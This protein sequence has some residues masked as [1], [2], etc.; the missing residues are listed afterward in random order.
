MKMIKRIVAL[1]TALVILPNTSILAHDING[2]Q[3]PPEINPNNIGWVFMTNQYTNRLHAQGK[4]YTYQY[5]NESIKKK[6]S[7]D[8]EAGIKLWGSLIKMKEK[9]KSDNIIEEGETRN[10][11]A[12]AEISIPVF[13]FAKDHQHIRKWKITINTEPSEGTP[14]SRM[15]AE[16]KSVVM[17]HEIG[18]A[19][20]LGDLRQFKNRGNLM[21]SSAGWPTGADMIG[22]EV[23]TGVHKNHAKGKDRTRASAPHNN[24]E[25]RR[26]CL[27][28]VYAYQKHKFERHRQYANG[29]AKKSTH[30]TSECDCG[31]KE[32]DKKHSYGGT[33][34]DGKKVQHTRATTSEHNEIKKCKGCS[35]NHSVRKKHSTGGKFSDGKKVRYTQATASKHNEIKK[36]KECGAETSVRKKHSTGGKFSDGKK[37]RYTRANANEHN[38]IKKCKGCNYE[39][40]VRKKH[41]FDK[42]GKCKDCG[43]VK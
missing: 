24:K 22:M 35:Y 25:C 21:Y 17:A 9:K 6:Y 37:V 8:F 41:R 38:E 29:S 10:R 19:Y 11:A 26:L 39:M 14:F 4:S 18:H 40:S 2:I 5:K 12:I 33:F 15:S 32:N 16:G 23:V 20:G 31:R 28:G 1:V 7:R 34:S 43:F 36:C 42:K 30:H 3:T 13:P 27:C